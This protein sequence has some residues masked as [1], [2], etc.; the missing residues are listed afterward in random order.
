MTYQ[1]YLKVDMPKSKKIILLV[2]HAMY[3]GGVEK[4]LLAYLQYLDTKK[5]ELH[6]ALTKQEGEL[7]QHL[8]K[9]V[10]LHQLNGNSFIPN[11]LYLRNL[12]TLLKTLRPALVIGFMQDISFNLL[13]VR[14]FFNLPT[15]ILISEH[16]FL[17]EWQKFMSVPWLKRKLVTFLYHKAD[18]IVAPSQAILEHL[19]SYL[20]IPFSKMSVVPNFI[21]LKKIK[22]QVAL[23]R[24]FFL[25]VGRFDS[26]KNIPVLLQ[27]FKN[28]IKNPKF[29]ALSLVMVGPKLG[30]AVEN[31]CHELRLENNVILSDYQPEPFIYYQKALGLIL[32]SKVEGNPRVVIEAMLAGCPVILSDFPGHET[33]VKDHLTGLVFQKTSIKEL[34]RCL[35]FFVDHPKERQSFAQA[36]QKEIKRTYTPHF[37]KDFAASLNMAVQ[38]A[39]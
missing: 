15:K 22:R 33:L 30:G 5:F 7:L 29:H 38:R 28:L 4:E 32:P 6:L 3:V 2:Y 11:V 23:P 25:F 16:I 20:Q 13:L 8:P 21:E 36:A 39:L 19:H 17:Q 31:L 26:Q 12:L 35:R 9:H 37:K 34:T 27:A 24:R 14:Y 18:G 1:T 10:H